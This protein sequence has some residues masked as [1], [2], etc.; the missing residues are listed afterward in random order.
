MTKVKV[1]LT[2]LDEL[3]KF[4]KKTGIKVNVG[5]LEK[6][7][8]R[9]EDADNAYIGAIHEFGH[10]ESNI[11]ANSFL[12]VPLSEEFPE[13]LKDA[14]L[15]TD[16]Q[17]RRFLE[18]GNTAEELGNRLGAMAVSTVVEAFTSNGFG[19]W[20]TKQ[21]PNKKTGQILVETGQLRD[22]IS[23]EVKVEK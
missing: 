2:G 5:I 22:S 3:H 7:S 20:S 23:Y 14:K 16:T 21:G 15:F 10:F 18:K 17:L 9:G 6:E 4:L 12:R 19:K 13:R 1:D 11:R 8:S